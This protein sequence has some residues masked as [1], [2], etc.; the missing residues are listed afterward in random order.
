MTSYLYIA[1]VSTGTFKLALNKAPL[2]KSNE[3]SYKEVSA[4]LT[5]KTCVAAFKCNYGVSAYAE[6][7][8]LF[9]T[10]YG[11]IE[12]KPHVYKGDEYGMCDL[13]LT[14]IRNRNAKKGGKTPVDSEEPREESDSPVEDASEE[15]EPSKEPK[16]EIDLLT[17]D[18]N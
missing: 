4:A 17:N 18:T 15:E 1:K 9:E 7:T 14:Y 2:K 16:Q 5:D 11:K 6:L 3:E 10:N 12:N 13:V 8:K